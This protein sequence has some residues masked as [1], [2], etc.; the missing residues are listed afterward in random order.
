M[1]HGFGATSRHWDG[2]VALADEERYSPAPIELRDVAAFG[3]GGALDQIAAVA[4]ERFVLCGYSMGGRVALHAA[5]AMPERI[6]RLVLVSTSGGIEDAATRAKRRADDE[7]LAASIERDGGSIEDFITRWRALPLFA[8]DPEWVSD[9]VAQ[10][11]RRLQAPELAAMLRG[12]G[13]GVLEPVWARLGTIKLPVVV[14]AG[15]RDTA[16][17]RHAER[18]VELLPDARLR[19]IKGAGHRVALEAPHAVVD[20]FG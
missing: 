14:I 1:V 5:L 16:Y 11:A 9:L 3:L 17:C 2:V 8:D 4:A 12:L 10:D 19:V 18:L 13:A 6:S 7:E 15:A 20:A